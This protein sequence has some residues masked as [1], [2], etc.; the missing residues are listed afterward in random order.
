MNRDTAPRLSR[1]FG[2]HVRDADGR[3]IGQVHEVRLRRIETATPLTAPD[4]KIEALIVGAGGLA[5]RLGFTSTPARAPWPFG[6]RA[7]AAVADARVVPWEFVRESG[8][9]LHTTL[10]LSELETVEA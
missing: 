3:P 10:A 9:E 8:E 2:R 4:F 5:L 7:R 1:M 6:A